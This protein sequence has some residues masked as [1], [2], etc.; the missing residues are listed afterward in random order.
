MQNNTD[1]GIACV[2]DDV[3]DMSKTNFQ[4]QW[5]ERE[6]KEEASETYR[7]TWGDRVKEVQ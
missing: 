6:E 7:E 1:F 5:C 2:C 3:R 4:K